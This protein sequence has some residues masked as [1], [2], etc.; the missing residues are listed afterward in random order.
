MSRR[1]DPSDTEHQQESGS[2]VRLGISGVL[3]EVTGNKWELFT[4]GLEVSAQ[5]R[6]GNP[7]LSRAGVPL[8]PKCATLEEAGKEMPFHL[9]TLKADSRSAGSNIKGSTNKKA[10]VGFRPF[11]P[12][13]KPDSGSP[14]A[15]AAGWRCGSQSKYRRKQWS[16]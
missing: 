9:L 14:F 4:M 1:Q 3:E 16:H 6:W 12:E 11:S 10:S 13:V 15:S 8:T 5:V 7:S 2:S